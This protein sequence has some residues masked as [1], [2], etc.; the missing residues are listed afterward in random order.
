MALD[1]IG[2]GM[3]DSGVKRSS[4][5]PEMDRTEALSETFDKIEEVVDFIDEALNDLRPNLEE[6][7]SAS[8]YLALSNARRLMQ[9]AQDKINFAQ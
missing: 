6:K 2:A 9:D 4:G 3:Y 1:R 5:E 7:E 8:A